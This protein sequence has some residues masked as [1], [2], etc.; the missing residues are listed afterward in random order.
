MQSISEKPMKL[1]KIC[2]CVMDCLVL[3]NSQNQFEKN[4]AK[5][6]IKMLND[7]HIN[8]ILCN[9][10][11]QIT[12]YRE[13]LKA[14]VLIV[15]YSSQTNN[16]DKIK[17]IINIA[18]NS[19]TVII[20]FVLDLTPMDDE[21]Y[22]FLNRKQ[23]VVVNDDIEQKHTELVAAVQVA[24]GRSS[25]HIGQEMHIKIITQEDAYIFIDDRLIGRVPANKCYSYN[26]IKK[27]SYTVVAKAV[28]NPLFSIEYNN[29]QVYDEDVILNVDFSQ[30]R[31]LAIKTIPERKLMFR[32]RRILEFEHSGYRRFVVDEK[33]WGFVNKYYQVLNEELYTSVRDFDGEFATIEKGE[34]EGLIDIFGNIVIAPNKYKRLYGSGIDCRTYAKDF[35]IVKDINNRMGVINIYDEVIYECKYDLICQY[36]NYFISVTTNGNTGI[37]NRSGKEFWNSSEGVYSFIFNSNHLL[38]IKSNNDIE[39]LDEDGNCLYSIT[40][41]SKVGFYH[42]GV[43]S[44]CRNDRWGL[45]NLTTQE[46]IVAPI[47]LSILPFSEGLAAVLNSDYKVGFVDERGKMVIECAFQCPNYFASSFYDKSQQAKMFSFYQGMCKIDDFKNRYINKHGEICL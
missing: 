45:M 44:F 11:I 3:Y 19:K 7:N 23:W 28:E 21:L 27:N 5:T 32:N 46:E 37:I 38:F 36:N 15:V 35:I 43:I 16:S 6:L 47:Y 41:C 10:N 22:Y 42:Q 33:L 17:S 14:S 34:C 13:K 4:V 26:A 31:E 2:K 24:L 18:F 1:L 40:D 29:V 20:P 30:Q 25:S 12:S 8:S 39:I 9:E